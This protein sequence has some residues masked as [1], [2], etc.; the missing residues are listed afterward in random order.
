[1]AGQLRYFPGDAEPLRLLLDHY[2]AA[3]SE[4]L[5][6]SAFSAEVAFLLLAGG[7]GRGEG[8]VLEK[9]G[10]CPALYNDIEF[11]LVL[12]NASARAAAEAWC[13]EESHRGEDETGIEVEFKVLALA[14]LA[15][16]EPSMF[17]YDLLAGHRL[18]HGDA[19]LVASLPARLRDPAAIP[20]HEATRLLFNRGTGLFYSHLRL[21]EAR[22]AADRAFVERNHAKVRLGLA[23]AVLA[24]NGCYHWSCKI[25]HERLAKPLAQVPCN[26]ATLVDW[27]A[28]AVDFKFHPRHDESS[29]TAALDEIQE[30]LEAAWRKVFLWLESVRLDT[31]F[32]NVEQYALHHGRMFPEF[33][34]ARNLA[35]HARDRLKRGN[36]PGS[37]FDYPRAPLQRALVLLLD[38]KPDEQRL[39]TVRRLLGVPRG[40]TIEL[41]SKTYRL[42]WNFYN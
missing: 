4:R 9:E 37:W 26:F 36:Q 42:W 27:H 14:A 22:A 29:S 28:S 25:R 19:S 1:M 7:Y 18:V 12:R 6:R 20:A 5:G 24:L 34:V 21:A 30:E 40:T 16:A 2:L 41:I 15:T 39:A 35:L 8:G 32:N 11:Y 3:L 10:T 17:Y 13:R 33:A 38:G 31:P 23:D